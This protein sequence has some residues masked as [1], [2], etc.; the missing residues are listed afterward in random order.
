MK[1][2]NVKITTAFTINDF[3]ECR[4]LILEYVEWLGFDL[5]FQNFEEEIDNLQEMYSE[6]HGGLLIATIDDI[7][8]GVAGIRKYEN[9]DCELKRMFVKEGYRHLGI[10]RQLLEAAIGLAKKMNYT[11][12]KLDTLSSMTSAIKLYLSYGFVEIQPY[13]YNPKE[14]ARFFERDIKNI[15]FANYQIN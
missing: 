1:P 3:S 8:V 5:C 12:I 2:Q 6:P 13:R 7:S 10:G 14:T 15:N 9:N 4:K 11:K